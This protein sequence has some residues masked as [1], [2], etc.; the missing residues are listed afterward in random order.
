MCASIIVKMMEFVSWTMDTRNHHAYV[1]EIG[2]APLAQ[3]H[4]HVSIVVVNVAR[5]APW[6]NA[7]K[8]IFRIFYLVPGYIPSILQMWRWACQSMHTWIIGCCRSYRSKWSVN[9]TTCDN[10]DTCGFNCCFWRS[11]LLFKVI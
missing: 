6:T 11:Y 10:D 4:Q 8:K 9:R 2:L 5:T 1:P 7:C 3:I